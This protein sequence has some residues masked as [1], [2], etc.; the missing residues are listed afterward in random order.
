MGVGF[1]SKILAALRAPRQRQERQ[2]ETG[3]LWRMKAEETRLA[4]SGTRLAGPLFLSA[5][6][7]REALHINTKSALM[8]L[9]VILGK[10]LQ[11]RE[12]E[13]E[14]SIALLRIMLSAYSD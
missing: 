4:H 2:P 1:L 13:K 10:A 14:R 9:K 12:R 3:D 8:P 7:V 5:G 11:A 6:S